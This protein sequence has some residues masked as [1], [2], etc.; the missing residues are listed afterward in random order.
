MSLCWVV[1]YTMA[2]EVGGWSYSD[3]NSPKKGKSKFLT[4][5]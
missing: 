3:S 4:Q 1:L 2:S 5:G